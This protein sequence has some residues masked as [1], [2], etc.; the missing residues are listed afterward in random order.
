VK[1]DARAGRWQF[2]SALRS[3][4]RSD[5]QESPGRLRPRR[6]NPRSARVSGATRKTIL[7]KARPRGFNPRSA[8]VSGATQEGDSIS[9]VLVFQS[10]LRSGERS[11]AYVTAAGCEYRVFQSAL[12][13]GERSDRAV[14]LGLRAC[15]CFNPRSARVS[16]ATARAVAS[17]LRMSVSIRAPL[18]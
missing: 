11:D 8:R 18:G 15:G 9:T 3:G 13:S 10:A 5:P 1:S 6:F 12:R 2:Q 14:R 17:S 16:G 4:E 7:E